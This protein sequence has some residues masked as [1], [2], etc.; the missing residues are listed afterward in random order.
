MTIRKSIRVER[1][2]QTAFTAFCEQIGKW[3]PI[4]QGFS[5][6]GEH[7][8]DI[9]IEGRVGGGFY[10][11]HSDGT[12]FEVGRVTAYQPPN[13][14]AFTW[15]GPNWEAATI[16]EVRF[17]ADGAGT[18]VDLEHSGWEH[19]PTMEEAGKQ[20]VGGW[21]FVLKQFQSHASAA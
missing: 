16:V 2:P 4:K 19:G 12:K 21:E 14:V 3:W 8:K 6:G 20:Y 1:P 13:L 18:R 9:V 17:V 11:L 10:E 5:F 15:R 7:T